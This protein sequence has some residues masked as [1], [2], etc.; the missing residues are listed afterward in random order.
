[1]CVNK[2]EWQ[3]SLLYTLLAREEEINTGLIPDN[4]RSK[5]EYVY[6]NFMD[7]VTQTI[8]GLAKCFLCIWKNS[9]KV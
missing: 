9:P 3:I 4:S 7:D 8:L 6:S 5:Y 1:M 2:N